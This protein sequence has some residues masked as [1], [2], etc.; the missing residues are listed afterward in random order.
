MAL[1]TPPSLPLTPCKMGSSSRPSLPTELLATWS[2]WRPLAQTGL[3]TPPM[4][5][6]LPRLGPPQVT[7]L[8]PIA[9]FDRQVSYMHPITPPRTQD[10]STWSRP[11][12]QY[13]SLP[14]H[15]NHLLTMDQHAHPFQQ[16]VAASEDVPRPIDWFDD[17]LKRS[18]HYIAEKTCEM[19]CYLWFS[20]SLS[21]PTSTQPL[22]PP[23]SPEIPAAT[24]S[25]Q[26]AASST[27]VSFMQKLLETTQVSQSVIVLSL[28]Y[29][30]RLKER[31]R[32]TA[33]LPGSEFRIAVAALMMANKFLDDNTY[34]NKTWSEVSG[35]EL[36][37]ITR[38]EKEFLT[39]IDFNLYI[40]KK[41]YESWM[42]L[43][44]GLVHAKER[45][46][47]RWRHTRARH[48][49]PRHTQPMSAAP[50]RSY[51]WRCHST[52]HRA[53]ST[54]PEQP[55]HPHA[56]PSP[57][58]VTPPNPVVSPCLAPGLK[59]SAADAFS[60]TSSSFHELPPLKRP[61]GMT[62]QIPDT[63]HPTAPHSAS[64]VESLQSF[65]KMS[66]SSSSSPHSVRSAQ[67]NSHQG[68]TLPQTLV[69]AYR[70]EGP[71]NVPQNLYYYSLAGSSTDYAAEEERVRRKAR[72]RC[73]QP[74]PP[75]PPSYPPPYMPQDIQSES[76][77][78]YEIHVDVR[79]VPLPHIHDA[80]WSRKLARP[81]SYGESSLQLPPLRE[82]AVPSAPFANAGPPG[83][84]FYSASS[85]RESPAYPYN[86][87]YGR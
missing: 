5:A 49:T 44:R 78:P 83:V 37:E 8:P 57:Y 75:P 28:H 36:A 52:S 40:S 86:W 23:Y 34:T 60:P 39:G 41:T 9:H 29:I 3:L 79:A 59:R 65:A 70:A 47:R 51:R 32:Y 12:Q 21:N 67:S 27:F 33:G 55:I 13:T 54:S 82:N 80:V 71:V 30:W 48:R 74:Q 84:H 22:T 53:R 38:M 35:I 64:P 11:A 77:S 4:S 50:I 25:L 56:Y 16:K 1:Y 81:P 68:D 7:S 61:T 15:L 76:V 43:L 46:C 58:H 63:N 87:S 31:N 73:Y 66:L 10:A 62:L 85:Q 72:L 69:A 14:C 20:M 19:I 2:A 24:S 6:S 45:E 17:S 42:H 18:P 26:L